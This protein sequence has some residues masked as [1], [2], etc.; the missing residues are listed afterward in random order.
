MKN[1]L[2]ILCLA[3]TISLAYAYSSRVSP[4]NIYEMIA[5]KEG[6]VLDM[7]A[8]TGQCHNEVRKIGQSALQN[9]KCLVVT[10][11]V[12]NFHRKEIFTDIDDAIRELTLEQQ[13]IVRNHP[14]VMRY[15]IA[16]KKISF[17]MLGIGQIIGFFPRFL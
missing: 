11:L 6:Q 9:D 7:Q 13:Q 1:I 2:I 12:V 4:T 17:D 10:K 3:L 14:K 16:L 15:F 8:A 5:E